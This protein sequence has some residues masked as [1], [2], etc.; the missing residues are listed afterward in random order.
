M[1]HDMQYVVRRAVSGVQWVIG[2][3][4]RVNGNVRQY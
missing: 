3:K 1:S 4:A 2:G